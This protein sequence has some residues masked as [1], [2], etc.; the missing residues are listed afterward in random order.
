[1]LCISRT[2]IL[3]LITQCK[4]TSGLLVK[5]ESDDLVGPL[6]N[7]ISLGR[8]QILGTIVGDEAD[9]ALE[10]LNAGGCKACRIGTI[11]KSEKAIIIK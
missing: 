5:G 1:V 11:D 6:S 7:R 9:K 10:V 3:S 8:S 2:Y 4:V